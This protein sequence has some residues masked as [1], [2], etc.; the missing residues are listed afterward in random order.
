MFRNSHDGKFTEV[1]DTAGL[2]EMRARSARGAAYF[3]YDND[4]DIDLVVS[5]I[6]EAPQLLANTGGN[7]QNWLEMKLT[8]TKSNRDAIG[9]R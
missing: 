6:D 5:N 2:T 7:R 9:A 8:G 1:S 4:G 3:D